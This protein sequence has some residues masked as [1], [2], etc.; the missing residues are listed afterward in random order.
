MIDLIKEIYQTVS[1]NKLR[2]ILTGIAV[3]W[4]IFMLIVLLSVARGVTTDFERDMVENNTASID[5]WSG[6][7]TKPYNGNREGRRIRL[8]DNDLRVVP[9]E[10][11]EYVEEVISEI[12][13]GSTLSTGRESVGAGYKGVYPGRFRGDE[14]DEL[15]DGRYINQ[16]DMDEKAKV[17]VLSKNYA[18]QLFPP[19]GKNAVGQRVNCN[20]LSFKVIGVYNSPRER[21]C[22]I[23]FTTARMMASD[24]EDLGS[25][26][27]TLKNVK[28]EEDGK[29]AEGDIRET[30]AREHDFDVKD[31]NAV[32]IWNSFTQ[33][34]K[35][36]QAMG[37]LDMGVWV[38]GVLTLLTGIVGISNIMFV[39]VKERTHEIGIRRAIGAKPRQILTQFIAE[40]VA[41]TVTF[42]Y[43]GIVL[44]TAFTQLLSTAIGDMMKNATVS[45]TI[46]LEVT[47]VLVV[48]G[49]LAGL[50]PALKALKVKPVEALSEE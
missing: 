17:I 29:T 7:T 49:A 23:P 27:V 9:Q 22:Y 12:N 1:T 31:E 28:T 47:L 2:T 39:T 36:S 42:G 3:T 15:Q 18:E 21:D 34:L 8:K 25:M 11:P 4:G 35:I 40:S 19:D 37:I 44:G 38:L 5:I 32:H 43:I 26:T 13:G 41:I 24:R 30:L 6:R 14:M 10:N 48:A 46:A 16:R 50:A 20:G 33:T 45:L